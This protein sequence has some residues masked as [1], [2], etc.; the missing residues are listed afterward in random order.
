MPL[1]L[2]Q[3]RSRLRLHELQGRGFGRGGWGWR[4]GDPGVVVVS[5]RPQRYCVDGDPLTIEM[6]GQSDEPWISVFERQ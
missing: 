1:L 2:P 6:W 4:P 3:G 5:E